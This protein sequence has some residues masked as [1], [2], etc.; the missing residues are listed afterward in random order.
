M[1]FEKLTDRARGFLQ[2]AQTIAVREHQQR[3]APAHRLQ[4][5]LDDDKRTLTQLSAQRASII[6]RLESGST[7]DGSAFSQSVILADLLHSIDGQVHE[8]TAQTALLTEQLSA[9]KTFN[10]HLISP[11]YS[12][13]QPSS[14]PGRFYFVWG[15]LLRYAA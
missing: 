3:R 13:L 12:P 1:D 6:S 10:T 11:I 14:A 4:A 9:E 5:L 8:V 2:A 15:L 7:R